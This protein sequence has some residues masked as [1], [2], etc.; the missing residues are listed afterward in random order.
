M[1]WVLVYFLLKTVPFNHGVGGGAGQIRFK[2]DAACKSFYHE[3]EK[4]YQKLGVNVNG[5]CMKWQPG[6]VTT[7]KNYWHK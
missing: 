4:N 7:H 1:H 3:L 6:T 5:V 2:T